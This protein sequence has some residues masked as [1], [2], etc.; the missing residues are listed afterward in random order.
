MIAGIADY[1]SIL[2]IGRGS[3][4]QEIKKAYYRKAKACHPDLFNNSAQKTEEFKIL[5]SAFDVLSDP[6]KRRRYD[7]RF[8]SGETADGIIS[9]PPESGLEASIMDSPADDILEELIVGNTCPE[10]TSLATLLM[11]LAKTEVFMTFREG[12]NLFYDK[13]IRAAKP[14]L[15]NAVSLSPYNIVYRV[16]LARCLAVLHEYG[17]AKEHYRAAL[18]IGARRSPVQRLLRIKNELEMVKKA[19]RPFWSAFMGLFAP[20]EGSFIINADEKLINETN[21][22]LA[23]LAEQKNLD[24]K[25][26][27]LLK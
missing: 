21:K 13:R 6:D 4:F 17:M 16:Y 10:K 25:G 19:H 24:D 2:E 22:M 5:V 12:K 27:K 15:L 14:F 18:E 7:K 11:D 23:K 8:F 26:K 9:E 3:N 1:Y 20:A